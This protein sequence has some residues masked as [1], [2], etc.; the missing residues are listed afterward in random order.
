M[1]KRLQID[2]LYLDLDT[3]DRCVAAD[4]TLREALAELS[5]VLNILGYAVELNKVNITTRELARQYCFLS[6][7]TI[8]VNGLDICGTITENG[9]CSCGTLCGGDV[10]CRTFSYDGKTYD[11][12]PKAMVMAGILR[13]IYGQLPRQEAA[14][15][16]PDNLERF[17]A[18]RGQKT[19]SMKEGTSLMKTLQIFE[20]AM[21]CPTGLCGVGVDPELL[22]ISTVLD[23]LNKKGVTV[24]RFN[25]NST[26][27]EF[28]NNKTINGFLN[29]QGPDGLPVAVLDGEIILTGRYPT[30]EEFTRW[31]DLPADLLGLPVLKIHLPKKSGN[32]GCRGGRC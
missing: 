14:Y 22:R 7:P 5:S 23:T 6:S 27:M 13:A 21:C 31:L 3:C 30:N 1:K 12:P 9:C 19:A 26:P 16:L 15:I 18:G 32:C 11:Q 17:F 24:D 10:N 29:D 4:G 2:F 8:R 28:V 25:L 20:P